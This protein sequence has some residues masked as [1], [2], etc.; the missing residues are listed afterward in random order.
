LKVFRGCEKEAEFGGFE[1]ERKVLK[2]CPVKLITRQST[3]YIRYYN[4][5]EKGFL[6]N[7]GGLL[8]QPAKFL[9][10]MNYMASL[11]A[12]IGAKKAAEVGTRRR[13]R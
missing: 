13:K 9:D 7:G 5:F 4:F 1:F 2:R 6:P 11:V 8:D 10:A 12:G 3:N